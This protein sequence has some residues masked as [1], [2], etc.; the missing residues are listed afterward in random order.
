MAEGRLLHPRAPDNSP[1][2]FTVA[3]GSADRRGWREQSFN[4]D[5]MDKVLAALKG[6]PDAYVSQATFVSP[7]RAASLTHTLR[8][9]WVD[10]DLYNLDMVADDA[11][12]EAVMRHAR[13]SGLPEP[14][15]VVSSG[16]GLYAKWVFDQPITS[17]MML[18][19]NALQGVLI[20]LFHQFGCDPKVRDAARV[21]RAASSIN[22]KSGNEVRVVRD[23]GRTWSFAHLCER[24]SQLDA[25]VA[26]NWGVKTVRAAQARRTRLATATQASD[27]GQLATYAAKREP[28]MLRQ[29]TAQSLNWCR[30]L[31][32]RDLAFQRGG[33]AR[34]YRDLFLFWMACFL[35]HSGVIT[36]ANFWSEISTLLLAFP[37][38]D[39]FDPLNDGSLQTLERRL[40][41]AHAGKVIEFEGSR[42]SPL[43]TPSN[44]YLLTAFEVSP[45]EE[46]RLRTVIS[47]AERRRRADQKVPG[48]AERRSEREEGRQVAVSLAGQGAKIEDI[49]ITVGRSRSTVYNWIAQA[50]AAAATQEQG[51]PAERRG[52]RSPYTEHRQ[53]LPKGARPAGRAGSPNPDR[54]PEETRPRLVRPDGQVSAPRAV[55][56]PASCASPR[57]QDGKALTERELRRRS[58]SAKAA[59]PGAPLS[60]EQVGTWVRERLAA[61]QERAQEASLDAGEGR[62]LADAVQA[63]QDAQA[64][65]RACLRLSRIAAFARAAP[66]ATNQAGGA[67]PRLNSAAALGKLSAHDPPGRAPPGKPGPGAG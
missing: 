58:A 50:R 9:A 49:A 41:A 59:S 24:V 13:N 33:F 66:A 52:R 31:D 55:S 2:Y 18:Q 62:R 23:T 60:A 43:Y 57:K 19:W 37:T 27:L 4:V 14:S 15:L 12:V 61:I 34:G 38:C 3:R 22:S 36:P 6:A 1:G 45:D 20:A 63:T 30:F 10:L 11:S 47:G 7:K 42:M 51:K 56:A 28:F 48:R 8:C 26:A 65:L 64:A 17:S 25:G 39:D 21:L 35:G 16:R 44:D 29:M 40:A 67:P 5:V 54:L 46:Q 32:L 53:A